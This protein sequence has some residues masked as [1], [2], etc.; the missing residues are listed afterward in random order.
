MQSFVFA[1]NA[2]IPVFLVIA[3][4]WFLN[5]I[6]L[7]NPG[8]T[9]AADQYVFKCA[10]PVS[11]FLSISGMDLYTDFHPAFCLFCFAVT[12]VI[13]GGVWLFSRLVLKDKGMIG[14]FTHAASRSSAAILGIAFAVNIYGDSGMIP[15]MIVSAVPF[16][17]IYSVLILTFSPQLTRPG[18]SSP[19]PAG[20][21]W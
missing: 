11:L 6:G 17:N 21:E 5:R 15:M 1:L 8:F 12:T 3:L 19:P 4:G 16:F 13:F 9:K 18:G 20:A 14:A 2:T 10:L 7:F